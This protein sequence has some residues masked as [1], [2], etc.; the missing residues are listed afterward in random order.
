MFTG[1]IHPPNSGQTSRGSNPLTPDDFLLPS[2]ILWNPLLTYSKSSFSTGLLCLKCDRVC[3]THY[4]ND[5][6]STHTQPRAI[7]DIQDIVYLVSAVYTCDEG[8]KILAHDQRVLNML[9]CKDIVPFVLL[10]RTGFTTNFISFCS[11]LCHTG[12]NFHSLE[13][14]ISHRRWDFY[15]SRRQA[16]LCT[17]S[18]YNRNLN[19]VNSLSFP[20]FSDIAEKYLP[21]DDIIRQCFLSN[22]LENERAYI[23]DI[24]S[25]TPGESLS[26]DHTFKVASNVGSLRADKK[27]ACEYDSAFIVFNGNGKIVS[28]QYTK[29]TSFE[30]V[31]VLLNNIKSRG[32]IAGKCTIKT[33][34]VDNCCH[35]RQKIQDVFGD[36]VI[37]LLDI[38]HAVQRITRKLPK[39]H[40]FHSVC[41]HELKL[42]F[43]SPGDYGLARTKPTP[44]P[45]QLQQ[46]IESFVERW[47]DVSYNE[48][49][50]LTKESIEEIERLKA[51]IRRGCLSAISVGGGTNQNEAFHRYINT[52]FHRSRIGKLLAYA[53]MMTIISHFNN[54]DKHSRKA[55][56]K[57][58]R[59]SMVD[60]NDGTV[61][62]KMGIMD[63][64]KN[65]EDITWIQ[66]DDEDDMDPTLIRS[67]VCVSLQQ[68]DMYKA[69]KRQASTVHAHNYGNTY[70]TCNY[71]QHGFHVWK[72]KWKHT[73]NDL[74][75]MLSL[76][77]LV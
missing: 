74:R 70:R 13:G 33:V 47:K 54:K 60:N 12:M 72:P 28:W 69:M 53:M 9:P 6:S 73:R 4:W 40:P 46:N 55:I 67:I 36:D 10:H 43:R 62:E 45:H 66:E 29:G 26:F 77:T 18:L 59:L 7:H 71:Y 22:F 23:C 27:W 64:D 14:A 38:F 25:V 65:E 19:N 2:I 63:C 21:S 52:F 11:S 58:I 5:G 34:Y 37:V 39:R 8:H 30:N 15:E 51:H 50:I 57:P 75:I 42:V 68:F 49:V 1:V 48:Q 16:Y 24:Q 32:T 76:G 3:N 17:S 56:T 44:Q 41:V 20:S 61:L 35:W 31:R